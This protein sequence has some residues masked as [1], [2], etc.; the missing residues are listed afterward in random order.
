LLRAIVV[1]MGIVL[2]SGGLWVGWRR[3]TGNTG[4]IEAGRIY[5][6]AQLDAKGL[7]RL[8]RERGIKTVLNL[9]GPNPDEAWYREELSATIGTGATQVDLPLASDQ[10]LSREQVETLLEVLDGCKYPILIHCEFGA[11]RT[12]LVAA[13]ATLLRPGSNLAGARAQFALGYLFLPVADGRVMVGHLDAYER[14]LRERG[15]VHSP[16]RLRTWLARDYR[17]GD[18]SREYWPCNPYPRKVVTRR[19]DGAA[20]SMVDASPRAC[21]KTVAAVESARR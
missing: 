4:T 14:W 9:R 21:P 16:E 13:L 12:G 6:S 2:L 3:G 5:R 19:V 18:P 20:R 1:A 15:A 17:P 8:I 10:W 7:K 11:E